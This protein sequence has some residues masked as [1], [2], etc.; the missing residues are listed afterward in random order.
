LRIAC[1]NLEKS[2]HDGVASVREG[3]SPEARR[4]FAAGGVGILIGHGGLNDRPET[5]LEAYYAY[6]FN[7]WR[8]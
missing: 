8:R 3:L 5:V 6:S 4:Y 7:K 2:W 1:N